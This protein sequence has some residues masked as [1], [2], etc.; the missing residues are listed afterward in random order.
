MLKRQDKILELLLSESRIFSFKE[1]SDIFN[2]STRSIRMDV[3]N[4]NYELLKGN[5]PVIQNEYGKGVFLSADKN[6]KNLI[7]NQIL[8]EVSFE[9]V[10][11]A[12]RLIIMILL[13]SDNSR[14]SFSKD[15]QDLFGLSKSTIDADM[16]QI[17]EMCKTFNI[18]VN[19][20][21][22]KG[23]HLTGDEYDIRLMLNNLIS[24]K[25]NIQELVRYSKT[26]EALTLSNRCIVEK[27][28]NPTELEKI[29]SLIKY[30]LKMSDFNLNDLYISQ[31]TIY[32]AIWKKRYLENDRL[33]SDLESI[34]KYEKLHQANLINDF[35][36]MFDLEDV[37]VIEKNYLDLLVDGLNFDKSSVDSRDWFTSQMLCVEMIQ[38]L[39]KIRSVN[40]NEDTKLFEAVMM[41]IVGIVK[42]IKNN[43]KI[44]NP[45]TEMIK[46]EYSSMFIDVRAASKLFEEHFNKIISDEEVAYLCMHFC[47]AEDRLIEKI[48]SKYKVIVVCAHG[49]V[50]GKVLAER[51]KHRYQFDIV[52][53]LN[54]SEVDEI[55]K[56]DA[57]FVL[58]TT[59]IEIYG[60]PSLVISPVPKAIDF[61]RIQKFIDKKVVKQN[62][63][64][65]LETN[66]NLFNDILSLI[67]TSSNNINL[68]LF[69]A[70]LSKIFQKYNVEIKRKEVYQPM[71]K[72][73]LKDKYILL[74]Q[75]AEDWKDAIRKAAQPLL[76]DGLIE[77]SYIQAMI[78]SVY[79]FGPYIVICENLALAHARPEAGVNQLGLSVMTLNPPV[80]FNHKDHDPVK[81]LFCLAAIDDTAHLRIMASLVNLINEDGKIDELCSQTDLEKFK[82]I[83][84][85]I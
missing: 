77:K 68:S 72:D 30:D 45:L 10:S 34:Y 41:H 64:T 4:I 9:D 82:E 57:D 25:I 74:N 32:L 69:E 6:E 83:L 66:T 23:L 49:I 76:E 81:I 42:R 62:S 18:E 59:N 13:I 84:F 60:K 35:F 37:D 36:K 48:N 58:K 39:S 63:E 43:V 26:H 79:E 61:E 1:L 20:H 21:V 54:S 29:N 52:A 55:S 53:I 56:I 50:T 24:S 38:T 11:R 15:Y 27:Y 47:A 7:L 3:Q 14:T 65:V 71:I 70:G 8:N 2:V 67:R 46:D 80:C 33:K 12:E 17:R 22:K 40:F 85:K 5:F 28:F 51:L 19:S 31:L 16:R 44:Y 75:K 73:I 78:D